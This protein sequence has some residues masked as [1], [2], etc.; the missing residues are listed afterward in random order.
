MNTELPFSDNCLPNVLALPHCR[1]D[2]AELFAWDLFH[3]WHIGAGKVFLGTAVVV[4]AMSEAFDGSIPSRLEEVSDRFQR[5]CS[6]HRLK[7]H[8]RRLSK[9]N[10]NWLTTT[11]YPSGGWSKGHT[12]RVLNK[13]F[14]AECRNHL[15][16]FAGDH[17][18]E[19]AYICA[20]S[21]ENFLKGLYGHELWIHCSTAKVIAAHGISFL[22][23]YGRGV[24]T[25]FRE[26][27]RLFLLQPNL[28][29]LHHIIRDFKHQAET[30]TWVLN[31][32]AFST[33]P[34]EDYI[35]RPSRVS[36]RVSARLVVQRTLQRSFIAAQAA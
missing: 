10:L 14:I 8:T 31:P 29:R 25:S 16:L 3:S 33:Q 20:V 36:R 1:D 23:H 2:P 13:W 6:E 26:G 9:E 4:L 24:S 7:P 28:H 22:K 12:T 17:L 35:G 34:E 5:W 27:K 30:C 15:E 18:L 19:I 21:I 32:L 11:T